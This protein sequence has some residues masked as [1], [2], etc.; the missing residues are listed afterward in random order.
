MMKVKQSQ[1][2]EKDYKRIFNISVVLSFVVA[3][4]AIVSLIAVGFNQVSY[5][6]DDEEETTETE[7]IY[8]LISMPLYV[9]HENEPIN[10][11]DDEQQTISVLSPYQPKYYRMYALDTHDYIGL[12]EED[13]ERYVAAFLMEKPNESD[14]QNYNTETITISNY[15]EKENLNDPGIRYIINKCSD[16]RYAPIWFALSVYYGLMTEDEINEFINNDYTYYFIK[17]GQSNKLYE[18]TNSKKIYQDIVEIVN[19]AKNMNNMQLLS[20]TNDNDT[21]TDSED[22]NYY[23]T[24]TFRILSLTDT[25]SKNTFSQY[26]LNITGMDNYT[27]VDEDGNTIDD[28]SNIPSTTTKFKIRIPKDIEKS[29]ISDLKVSVSGKSASSFSK[30]QSDEGPT[31]FSQSIKKESPLITSNTIS[32][33]TLL[34]EDTGIH[35]SYLKYILGTLVMLSGIGLAYAITELSKKDK[36]QVQ[37]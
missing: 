12:N 33:E 16:G 3:T 35:S 17:A 22:D 2:N 13:R 6:A 8:D 1:Y 21:I 32:Y 18:M 26:S 15:K 25:E 23:E 29:K 9:V 20:L 28:I 14:A 36:K 34:T 10:F 31:I 19:E 11:D 5:A 37:Q 30:Y 4:F 24:A 7:F 27:V